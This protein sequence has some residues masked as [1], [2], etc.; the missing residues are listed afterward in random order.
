MVWSYLVL[1]VFREAPLCGVNSELAYP[2]NLWSR[3]YYPESL[4]V[5]FVVNAPPVFVMS[6][7]Q[8]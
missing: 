5:L 8:A 3:G 1:R 2:P 7:P 4:A 6:R